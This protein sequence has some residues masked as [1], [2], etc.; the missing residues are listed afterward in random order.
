MKKN[1]DPTGEDLGSLKIIEKLKIK[2]KDEKVVRMN[3]IFLQ[4]TKVQNMK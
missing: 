2:K 3:E 1:N 4:G